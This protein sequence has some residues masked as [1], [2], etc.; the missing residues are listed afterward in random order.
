[1]LWDAAVQWWYL[2]RT[3]LFSGKL[4]IGQF[5]QERRWKGKKRRDL[6]LE[7]SHKKKIGERRRSDTLSTA[8]NGVSSWTFKTRNGSRG[9]LVSVILKVTLLPDDDVPLVE[10][11]VV[12]QEWID[13]S[14]M[15]LQTFLAWLDSS[16]KLGVVASHIFQ[17]FS[18]PSR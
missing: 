1:M 11:L 10:A 16:M 7:T 14:A 9:S 8:R 17:Y 3:D 2:N 18:I 5:N 15:D 12:T 6:L 13:K 4:K